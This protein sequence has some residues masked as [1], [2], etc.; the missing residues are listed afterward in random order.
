MTSVAVSEPAQWIAAL[1]DAVV[2]LDSATN[3]F[4]FGN[5]RAMELFG[6]QRERLLASSPIDFSPPL[7]PD[8]RA[9]PQSCLEQLRTARTRGSHT[10]PWLHCDA[11][12]REFLCE[13]RLVQLPHEGGRLYEA[14]IRPQPSAESSTAS[15]EN[16]AVQPTD[17]FVPY[18]ELIEALPQVIWAR[19][20]E[21]RMLYVNDFWL[22]Y[23]GQSRAEAF[24]PGSWVDVVHPDD[25]MHTVATFR[26]AL[27]RGVT[28]DCE[29]R[30]RNAATGQYRWFHSCA[31]CVRDEA[32]RPLR[33]LGTAV[34]VED[35]KQMQEALRRAEKRG[36]ESLAVLA[37]ELRNPL[38]ALTAALDQLQSTV[39]A[40]AED[41][42]SMST[43]QRQLG[44][45]RQIIDDVLE[46][47]R[48]ERGKQRLRSTP[49]DLAAVVRDALDDCGPALAAADLELFAELPIRRVPLVG[50]AS[51]LTQIL[52]N[53]LENARKFTPRGGWVRV[54]LESDGAAREAVLAVT[55]S[56]AGIEPALL[57]A[58]F[59]PFQQAEHATAR[60]AGLGLGLAIVHRLVELHGGRV[61]AY[62]AGRNRGTT[63]TVRLPMA[64]EPGARS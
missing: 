19:D 9:T 60:G 26:D 36:H 29:H 61:S 55:D 13:V 5:Q 38:A 54:T 64:W 12:G 7:Q 3:R 52:T 2:V 21:G 34:D 4:V 27:A 58:V 62:S 6:C 43:V 14:T 41:C 25:K 45:L 57:G 33:W 46:V 8:G 24:R 22:S 11:R 35:F 42:S 17:A 49:L 16:I 32:G 40:V 1:G 63:I 39:P 59:E 18:R 53:L 28:F 47:S 51:R 15:S 10:F 20:A 37:H 48:L 31:V 30:V 44:H 23:S 50:D 56:G